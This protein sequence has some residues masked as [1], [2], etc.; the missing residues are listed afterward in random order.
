MGRIVRRAESDDSSDEE[1][2]LSQSQRRASQSTAKPSSSQSQTALHLDLDDDDKKKLV[3]DAVFYILTQEQKRPV[4]KKA[5]ILKAI[6]L[7]TRAAEVRNEIWEGI[8]K[9]LH[10]TLGLQFK[11]LNDVKGGFVLLNK[12]GEDPN[13]NHLHFSDK[14]SAHHGLL[15]SVLSLIYMSPGKAVKSDVMNNF[16]SKIGV[17]EEGIG[18]NQS[19]VR[20]SA[21]SHAM[22][23]TF[24]DAKQL[25]EKEWVRQHYI[26]MTKVEQNTVEDIVYEYRW[27]ERAHIEI[28]PADI[29]KFVANVYEKSPTEF[30]EQYDE[31]SKDDPEAFAEEADDDDVENEEPVN[32]D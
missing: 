3:G 29:L 5:D 30:R 8:R 28:K 22:V 6:G 26:N 20:E 7:Q 16:L 24:G 1:E 9:T 4:F 21:V 15:F 31:I 10:R 32:G 23:Q 19:V 25:I 11:E 17:W 27:G 12:L 18:K 14:E 13:K 2:T